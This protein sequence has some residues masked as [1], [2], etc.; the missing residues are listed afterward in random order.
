MREAISQ[1][2]DCALE[3]YQ[4]EEAFE[5]ALSE[6]IPDEGPHPIIPPP[7]M[8]PSYTGY[9]EEEGPGVLTEAVHGVEYEEPAHI[10][11]FKVVESAM[12]AS[13]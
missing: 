8:P 3:P 1:L 2:A 13:S 11:P 12:T 4:I 9:E 7:L 10:P 6:V 5:Q